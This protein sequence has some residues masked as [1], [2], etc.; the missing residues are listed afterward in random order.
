MAVRRKKKKVEKNPK[1][2]CLFCNDYTV[3]VNGKC[4]FCL[5]VKGRRKHLL[6]NALS[7]EEKLEIINNR[8][9]NIEDKIKNPNPEIVK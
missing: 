9:K 2:Y 4:A 3:S 7:V 8:L 6:W 5:H 1:K